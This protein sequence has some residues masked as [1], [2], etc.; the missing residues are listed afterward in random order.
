M[1]TRQEARGLIVS[2]SDVLFDV[3]RATLKPGA[4]ERL[5]RQGIL[6]AYPGPVPHE[7]EGHTDSAGADDYNLRLSQQDRA[8]SVRGCLAQAR[9]RSDRFV[10]ARGLGKAAPVVGNDTAAG[11]QPNRRVEIIVDDAASQA[12]PNEH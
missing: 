1:E 7:I 10:A 3:N 9:I 12:R 4:R 2:R 6:F 11:R 5:N 8:E